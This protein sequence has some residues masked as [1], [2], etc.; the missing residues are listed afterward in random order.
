M[1]F[2]HNKF[3]THSQVQEQSLD[4]LVNSLE[5]PSAGYEFGELPT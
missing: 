3:F 2:F 1:R 4:E 5:K